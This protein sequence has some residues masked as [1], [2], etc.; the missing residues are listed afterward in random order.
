MLLTVFPPWKVAVKNLPIVASFNKSGEICPFRGP[1]TRTLRCRQVRAGED[2]F[3]VLATD[4]VTGTLDDCEIVEAIG[5]C[6]GDPE[7]AAKTLTEQALNYGSHDN[8]TAV[9][10]ALGAWGRRPRRVRPPAAVPF[11]I[12]RSVFGPRYNWAARASCPAGPARLARGRL[13]CRA[14]VIVFALVQPGFRSSLTAA[15]DTFLISRY[16]R[17]APGFRYGFRVTSSF[18]VKFYG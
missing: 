8:L 14:R 12:G 2:A 10:V 15:A 1:S 13:L 11:S 7:R 5:E 3:L 18:R 17:S 16:L 6:G 9:V 4:G